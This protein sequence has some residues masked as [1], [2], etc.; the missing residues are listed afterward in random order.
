M[1]CPYC[2]KALPEPIVNEKQDIGPVVQHLN[3]CG[4]KSG[5]ESHGEMGLD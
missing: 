5:Y 1:Q 4:P 2:N 3:D